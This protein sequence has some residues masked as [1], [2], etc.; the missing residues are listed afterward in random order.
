MEVF[1]WA[2][3]PV[4]FAL[5]FAVYRIAL[6]V[7][8]Y[9]LVDTIWT[10]GLG[11]SAMIYFVLTGA[12]GLR[13]WLIL[14]V[15][16][17]WSA[18]LSRHLFQDRIVPGHEDPRY[19]ALAA[20]W[21]ARADR[22]FIFLFLGQVPLVAL[23]LFPVTLALGRSGGDWRWTDSLGLVIAVVALLGEFLADQQ[24]ARFRANSANRGG[25]CQQGLWRYSRHPNYF[26][27]WLYWF[28]YAAFAVGA[29]HGAWAW[30]GP[31]MMYLFL[32]Y[33]TGVPFAERSSLRSRGEA[34]RHYQKTTSV[35]FPWK[36][37]RERNY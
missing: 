14:G 28:S 13:D 31:V 27:E 24:L 9:A 11:L 19:A 23:F 5:A 15:I 10:T 1:W 7:R 18:R 20:H 4:G 32:R 25:V 17:F 33:I 12:N 26:F 22:N 8:L 21:G 6:R 16:L 36:P 35:F 2:F 29:P 3:F 30:V 37:Q 34:Y